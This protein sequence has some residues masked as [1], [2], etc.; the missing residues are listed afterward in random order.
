MPPSLPPFSRASAM[1]LPMVLSLLAATVA[2]WAISFLSFVV[3]DM[4]FKSA[5]TT[6]T[7]CSIPRLSPIG[8][9][10]AVT[11]FKPSRKIAWAS[12]VAVVVPSPAASEVFEAT[13][14]I[15]WAPMFS[16]GSFSCT[17]LATVTPSLVVVGLPYFLSITTFRPL[18]PSVA[19]TASARTFTPRRSAA[20]AVWS[21]IS[22]FAI[23]CSSVCPHSVVGFIRRV[24]VRAWESSVEDPEDVIL[25]HDEQ[26]LAVDLHLAAGILAEE[27]AVPRLHD[28]GQRLSLLGYPAGAGGDDLALLGLLLGAVRDDDAAMHIVLLLETLDEDPVV[29]RPQL[30]LQLGCGS[31]RAK[32]SF[33]LV[34]GGIIRVTDPKTGRSSTRFW[35]VPMYRA[36]RPGST[37]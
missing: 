29:E 30:R 22:C 3:L 26:L 12:T 5:T 36:R 33:R 8:F 17:S 13:S 16:V 20:R 31:H 10:P 24:G 7:A 25:F 32:V 34:G 4:V 15:I 14:L 2:T 1:R 19:F 27:N 28:E 18:G 6:S 11:F 23:Y 35:R 37:R 9:A 21:N